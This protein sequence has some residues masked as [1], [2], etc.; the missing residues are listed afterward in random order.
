MKIAKKYFGILATIAVLMG[1][2]SSG[3]SSEAVKD[4]VAK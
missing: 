4:S 2:N 1:C 3:S